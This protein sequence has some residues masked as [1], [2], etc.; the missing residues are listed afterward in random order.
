MA[1]CWTWFCLFLARWRRSCLFLALE[2]SGNRF[3]VCHVLPIFYSPRH[4]L[5]FLAWDESG[6]RVP[7][8]FLLPLFCSPRHIL[9]WRQ[10][11][12]EIYMPIFPLYFLTYTL[13]WV[14][15]QR[16]IYAHILGVSLNPSRQTSVQS[17]LYNM[18]LL[19]CLDL[20][21]AA[22]GVHV[23]C[24]LVLPDRLVFLQSPLYNKRLL[25]YFKCSCCPCL[26]LFK[27]GYCVSATASIK[28]EVAAVL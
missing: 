26:L 14:V 11:T 23:L 18:R 19:K 28:Q 22:V 3:F 13:F 16:R 10:C 2:K 8:C 20:L 15:T 12:S 21:L 6:K 25:K 4:I 7:V 17:P 5:L 24:V 1:K 27:T 9:F